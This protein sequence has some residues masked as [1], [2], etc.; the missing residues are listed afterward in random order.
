MTQPSALPRA[1]VRP[2]VGSWRT[3]AWLVVVGAALG[4]QSARAGSLAS[5]APAGASVGVTISITGTGFD[6]T[7][8]AN[9]VTFTP[10]AGAP[11][12]AV[13]TA[14]ATVDAASGA[15]RLSVV[16]PA[17]L[18]VGPTAVRVVNTKSGEA[19]EGR[20]VEVVT[21]A[22]PQ[23]ASGAPGTTGLAVRITGSPNAQFAAGSRV[24]VGAGITVT[25]TV[26]ESPTSV[27][28]TLT[29]AATAA[30]GPRDVNL[31]TA[32]QTLRLSGGFTVQAAATN[33]APIVS[34]GA[35]ATITLPATASL[36]GTVSDDGL[37]TG[38]L[39]T[40]AWSKSSGPGTVAF[41]NGASPTTTATFSLGG[42]LRVA[43]DGE[44]HR[45]V[46]VQRGDHHGEPG[47]GDAADEPG[48]DRQRG[49]ER[50][51]H[52]AGHGAR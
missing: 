3:A 41:A 18:P 50:D 12:S 11:V 5:V 25:S 47:G 10:A 22:L 34:A 19:S 32:T 49:H 6:P 9:T 27:L 2:R 21:L 20:S 26:V 42:H 4:L 43:A 44:R 24:T 15:R 1:R 33:L 37:P 29:I 17:G 40:S 38:A 39:V 52:A 36:S 48:A 46:G 7:A 30:L 23:T 28:A 14:I 35:N 16:V 8:A 51:D 45:A 31:I 13:G